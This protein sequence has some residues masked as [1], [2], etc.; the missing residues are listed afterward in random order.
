[1]PTPRAGYWI[2]GERV[3]S[4]SSI[5]NR[6]KESGALINWS[7]KI[8]F[9]GLTKCRALLSEAVK[10]QTPEEWLAKAKEVEEFLA[11]PLSTW[12][13]REVRQTAA[14]AGTIA[15]QMMDDFVHERPFDASSYDPALIEMAKPPFQAF[16][17][18]AEGHKFKI[19]ETEVPL[20]SRRY[21]F[22]GTRDAIL[23]NDKRALGDWKTSRSIYPEY[24]C[25]LGAYGILDEEAG[26]KID[27][28]YHL[29]RFSKQEKPTDP[30]SFSHH[31]WS[32]MDAGKDAFI[33]MRQLYDLMAT[34]KR[35]AK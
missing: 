4:Y 16:L 31:Y 18:W 11:L 6:F 35:L 5:M 34:L 24:L 27:G 17:T 1:M 23:V 26:F 7:W 13:Y 10:V 12:D 30:V 9:D 19:I 22:G 28:G 25:Q 32:Q 14:D 33:L 8:A 3:P 21:K 2:D 29:L 20:T 15:H